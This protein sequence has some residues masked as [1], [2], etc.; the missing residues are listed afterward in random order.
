MP[1]ADFPLEAKDKQDQSRTSGDAKEPIDVPLEKVSLLCEELDKI[2]KV[3]KEEEE[4]PTEPEVQRTYRYELSA[5]E[6]KRRVAGMRDYL[7]SIAITP[8]SEALPPPHLE[9]HQAYM[10]F[11]GYLES[12]KKLETV[13]LGMACFPYPVIEAIMNATHDLFQPKP[14]KRSP[15]EKIEFVPFFPTTP[16]YDYEL[17]SNIPGHLT[18]VSH[19]LVHEAITKLVMD[20]EGCDYLTATGFAL[21]LDKPSRTRYGN[22]WAGLLAEARQGKEVKKKSK[23]KQR[24]PK[25]LLKKR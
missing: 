19:V 3:M 21:E 13:L 25:R 20:I 8:F 17:P 5:E 2:E 16:V 7:N 11:G 14:R 9:R 15:G 18:Y 10:L 23:R 4:K 12:F 22:R 24:Q 6:A 1:N